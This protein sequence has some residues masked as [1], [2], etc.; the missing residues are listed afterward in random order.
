MNVR[1]RAGLRR[2]WVV[3]AERLQRNGLDPRGRVVLAGLDRDERHAIAGL[4]GRPVPDDRVTL[5]L[6]AL[7]R[8]LRESGGSGLVATVER[9]HGPLVDRTGQRQARVD[10]R[11]RVWLAGREAL[12]AAGLAGA[13]WVEAWLDDVRRAGALGRLAPERA[14]SELTTAVSC[15]GEL[16]VVRGEPV[17]ARGDLASRVAGSAHALDDGT[18]LAS[19]V[20]RAAAAMS[21]TDYPTTAAGRRAMWRA[22]GVLT[23]EVSTTA[24]TMGLRTVGSDSWL[25]DRTAARWESHLTGRDLRRIALRAPPVVFVCENPRV[26][27]AALDGGSPAAVVCTQGQP[28]VVVTTLLRMLRDGGATLR[29][30]GDFDWPG[31]TIANG[32][33]AGHGCEPWQL[34]A[35]DYEAALARLAAMVR[36]LPALGAPP[37]VA[38]WDAELSAAMTRAGRAV[39]EEL[40]LDE[41]LDDLT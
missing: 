34:A 8:R 32:L 21:R 14:A 35:A 10:A 17:C 19:L 29:Y 38:S 27:E 23:D 33:M 39:H 13:W 3:A 5:D 31:I 36:E 6:G 40:V 2:L 20:L 12:A 11:A 1:D 22:V 28:S 4:L 30:H 18:V 37:V 24:L 15:A 7:D 41:L 9:M 25:D 16:P 26:L